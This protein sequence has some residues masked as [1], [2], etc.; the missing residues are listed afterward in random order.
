MNIPQTLS[1]MGTQDTGQINVR[2]KRRGK[3]RMN[4]PQKLSTLGT[5]DTEQINVREK[6][7]GNQE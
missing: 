1:T 7:R 5:Q 4:N 6:R 2:E 3:S